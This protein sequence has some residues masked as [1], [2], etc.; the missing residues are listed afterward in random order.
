MSREKLQQ[1]VGSLAST[2]ENNEKVAT[3]ILAAKLAKC[4]EAY[5]EDQTIGSMARVID[6][7]AEN[8]TLFIRK[9]ELK[10]LYN[11]LYTRNTKFAS[12]FGEELGISE[13]KPEKSLYQRD[14]DTTAISGYELG[15]SIL[16]NAL[17][18]VFDKH[19]PLKM[20][21]QSLADKALKSV[22]FALD[23]W[24]LKPS[25][26]CVEDGN[27]K[28]LVVKADYETPKGLTSFYVPVETVNN[29]IIEASLFM[30][31]AGPQELNNANIKSYISKFAGSKLK[32]SSSSILD[33]IVKAASENREVSGVELAMTRLNASR[34]VNSE[35]FQGQVV[36]LKVA[37][38]A[39]PEIE[40]SKSDEF[41]SFEQQFTSPYGQ[42]SFNF[43]EDKVKLA[44]EHIARELVGLGQNK[45]QITV[46][47]SD[48]NTIFYGVSLDGGK[49]AFTVP[50]KFA[51]NKLQKPSMLICNGSA[52]TFDR[53]GIEGLYLENKT[54]YKVAAA[55]SPLF[56][57]KPSDLVDSIRSAVQ[58]GNVAKA[59]DALNVLA[60]SGD[61]RAYLSGFKVYAS[62]L[63]GAPKDEVT[64]HPLY[65]PNDFY[66]SASSKLPIS[67]QTNL[68][69]NKI[70]IDE[71]GNHRPLYRRGMSE[72]YEGASFMNA[73][74]FG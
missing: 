70:Y 49:L 17:N 24:N 58:E 11:K 43:G 74:I 32:V 6:K 45:A 31:N 46:T 42:A 65:N 50:V 9:A 39:K 72:T 56:G 13:H 63:Q 38:A 3:P 27:E 60:T 7:M 15:D 73:K 29:K 23:S 55:A 36:G 62:G 47:S 10:S 59:E 26:I 18:S 30:G 19:V 25:N 57:L 22:A 16:S 67:K 48:K 68:P 52:T 28:F 53:K 8:N 20:Y 34:Q 64:S 66:K 35:F 4:L 21:S 33:V 1:L 69:I 71:N 44:R 40:F 41:S 12:L 51:G 61:P 2:L 5:P 37:E 14:E 54:D